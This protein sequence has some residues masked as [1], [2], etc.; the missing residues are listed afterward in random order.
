MPKLK[1]FWFGVVAASALH[2]ALPAQT[3]AKQ[4]SLDTRIIEAFENID[5]RTNSHEQNV[6]T[7]RA[8]LD[9]LGKRLKDLRSELANAPND[10]GDHEAR[11]ER[12]VL[13][14][15]L[16]NLS[17]EYLNQSYKLVDSAAAVISANLGDLSKLADAV[18]KSPDSKN[19]A[20]RLN[21][22]VRE[23]IEAGR[24]MRGALLQLRHW[25]RNNPEMTGRFQSLKRLTQALD[26]RISIDKA[27][28]ASRHVDATGAIRSKR[29]DALD[30]TVDRLGDMYAEVQAEKESLKDLRDELAIA[31]QLGRMEMTQEIAD[32][33]IP[34]VEGFKAPTTGVDS[35]K[36]LATVIGDLNTSMISEANMP[37]PAVEAGRDLATDAGQPESLKIGGFNNF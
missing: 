9:T 3:E 27:R 5:E 13:H 36:D 26:R 17:A 28:L 4:T 18:R 29:Q 21:K 23:N 12:R 24:S 8:R 37:S 7:M 35:L 16:I 33:A 10:S 25:A 6:V 11:K 14:G 19:G 15:K 34:R 2:L 22:R 1:T 30:R 20:Q 32:R 31:I